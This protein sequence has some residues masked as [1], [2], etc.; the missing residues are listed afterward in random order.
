M[1]QNEFCYWLKGMLDAVN[2][3][4]SQIGIPPAIADQIKEKLEEVLVPP[5]KVEQKSYNPLSSLVGGG[6]IPG[7]LC[8]NN[9]AVG[10]C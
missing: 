10:S 1:N 9:N 8:N 6:G 3:V 5:T 4:N 7:L 2:S